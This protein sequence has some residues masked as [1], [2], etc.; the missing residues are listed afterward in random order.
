M[1]KILLIDDSVVDRMVVRRTLEQN[2]HEVFESDNPAD[3][4]LTIREVKPDLVLLDVV[5]PEMN[6][7]EVC[8]LLKRQSSFSRLP[9]IFLSS[10]SRKSDIFWGLHQ[11]AEDYLTKPVNSVELL[12]TVNK[13]LGNKLN[14]GIDG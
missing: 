2:A 4:L 3:A 11:G 5:M 13:W 14:V 7:Y 8:R 10:R 1:A 9:V 12:E 6:G